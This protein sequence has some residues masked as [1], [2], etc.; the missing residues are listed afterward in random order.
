[1]DKVQ[2]PRNSLCYSPSSQPFRNYQIKILKE[3]DVWDRRFRQVREDMR[4]ESAGK[5]SK[6][7]YSGKKEETG[8]LLSI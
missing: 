5:K 1:M 6:S 4:G 8:D 2:K 7:I 3:K